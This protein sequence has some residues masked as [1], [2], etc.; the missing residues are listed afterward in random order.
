MTFFCCALEFPVD[1]IVEVLPVVSY[2]K[3]RRSIREIK[4]TCSNIELRVS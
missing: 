2:S 3:D 1:D 4:E